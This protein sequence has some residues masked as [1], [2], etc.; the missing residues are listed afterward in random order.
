MLVERAP[1]CTQGHHTS[2]PVLYNFI[3]YTHMGFLLG[4]AR[5]HVGV[6]GAEPIADARWAR[7][8]Q[9]ARRALPIHDALCDAR[10]GGGTCYCVLL[11]LLLE[12]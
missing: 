8:G 9:L 1:L 11:Y 2:A 7:T 6:R 5:A 4:L 3:L 12:V 10:A